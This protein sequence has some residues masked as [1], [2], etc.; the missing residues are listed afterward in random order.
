MTDEMKTQGSELWI[1]D[2]LTNPSTPVM[3]KIANL[4][5][6][7]EFGAQTDDIETTNLDSKAKEYIQGLPDNGEMSLTVN[8][9]RNS[10][11][12]ALLWKLSKL[13]G[14]TRSG[15]C[16]GLSDGV[17]VPTVG[18][19]NSVEPPADRTW[20]SGLAGVKSFRFPL[21]VNAVVKVTITLRISGEIASSLDA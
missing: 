6:V 20:F 19:A 17:D 4:T 8:L 21:G 15:W 10:A 16:I 9:E 5:D 3:V 11:A 13:G 12:H 18:S 14:D 2:T 7:G 1:M